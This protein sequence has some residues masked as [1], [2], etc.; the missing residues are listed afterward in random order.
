MKKN[1]PKSRGGGRK[2]KAP[3]IVARIT[4]QALADELGISLRTVQRMAKSRVI[5]QLPDG[6]YDEHA[7]FRA[8]AK[9]ALKKDGDKSALAAEKLRKAILEADALQRAQDVAEGKL[10]SLDQVA[11]VALDVVPRIR[12]LLRGLL[13]SE[14]PTKCEGRSRAQIRTITGKA[15]NDL[16]RRLQAPHK[17]LSTGRLDESEEKE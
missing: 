16:L 17:A 2:G 11:A 12:K 7:T 15:Y 4:G 9:H 6:D 1:A 3:K 13:L 10:L 14:L 8:I 5:L